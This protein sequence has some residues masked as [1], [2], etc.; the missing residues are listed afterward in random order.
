MNRILNKISVSAG[1]LDFATV[2][3]DIHAQLFSA[4]GL[5]DPPSVR[6]A[7]A[8]SLAIKLHHIQASLKV[9]L[10][11]TLKPPSPDVLQQSSREDAEHDSVTQITV[12]WLDIVMFCLLTVVYRTLPPED[13]N[14]HPLQCCDECIDAARKALSSLVEI[15][16]RRRKRNTAA[17]HH[18]LNLY[19]FAT[20]NVRLTLTECAG[21][22]PSCRLSHFS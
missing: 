7:N 2:E 13:P 16:E 18:F 14:P 9:S 19:A 10:T 22:C 8:K 15:G 1:F 12:M 6:A 17:W 11:V 20:S 3:A 21:H 5:Q 4:A